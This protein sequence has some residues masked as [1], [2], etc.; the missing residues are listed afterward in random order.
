LPH[1]GAIGFAGPGAALAAIRRLLH[2]HPQSIATTTTSL[3]RYG[4]GT[5]LLITATDAPALARLASAARAARPLTLVLDRGMA[6][7]SAPPVAFLRRLGRDHDR[8]LFACDTTGDDRPAGRGKGSPA[9]PPVPLATTVLALDL[10]TAGSEATT[11]RR[12]AV[13]ASLTDSLSAWLD[14]CPPSSAIAVLLTGVTPSRMA[15]ARSLSDHVVRQVR[16]RNPLHRSGNVPVRVVA[17]HDI[18]SGPFEVLAR[19]VAIR[20]PRGRGGRTARLAQTPRLPGVCA[21]VLADVD[22]APQARVQTTRS[23]R[24]RARPTLSGWLGARPAA[25]V[26]IVPRDASGYAAR[27][28]VAAARAGVPVRIVHASG[29]GMVHAF[30]AAARAV[31]PGFALLVGEPGLD[32]ASVHTVGTLGTTMQRAI[33]IPVRDNVEMGPIFYPADLHRELARVT[34]ATGARA[35]FEAHPTRVVHLRMD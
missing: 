14:A 21:V 15:L 32:R 3:D 11:S 17:T 16:G 29:S 12:R 1:R 26:V 13:Q 5:G 28:A 8:V 31:P 34:D 2:E 30:R 20:S 24:P 7:F 22:A 25:L 6:R 18:A 4:F 9:W 10:A 19:E 27:A 23:R 33:L 35:L